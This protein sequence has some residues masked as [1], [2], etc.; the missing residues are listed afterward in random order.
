L[1]ALVLGGLLLLAGVAA[2]QPPGYGEGGPAVSLSASATADS[3][4]ATGTGFEA[5]EP[6]TATVFSRPVVLGA[7]DADSTGSVTFTFSVRNL[8]PG[9]HRIVLDAPSGSASAVF[10][11]LA[12]AGD[13]GAASARVD[14][15]GDQQGGDQ[16]GGELA[17]TG[18][19]LLVP[20]AVAGLVL[21][22]GGAAAVVGS[23]RKREHDAS[24]R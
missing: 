11:V 4:T 9:E 2:A 5:G 23:R 12:G 20:L 6:V 18:S 3:I 22:L 7:Q 15:G 14:D 8:E 21:V 17:Y 24:R 13:G 16:Q 19:D 10:T 1:T